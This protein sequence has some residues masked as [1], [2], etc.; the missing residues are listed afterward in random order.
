MSAT[1]GNGVAADVEL[2]QVVG[3]EVDFE[4]ATGSSAF[5]WWGLAGVEDGRTAM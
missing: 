4:A 2:G 3:G 5:H 1:E